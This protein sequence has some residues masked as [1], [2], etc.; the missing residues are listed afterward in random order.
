MHPISGA[1]AG[2]FCDY[3]ADDSTRTAHSARIRSTQDEAQLHASTRLVSQSFSVLPVV[4]PAQQ[5]G[6]VKVATSGRAWL[7]TMLST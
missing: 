7:E 6:E 3:S 5:D 4:D 1:D 2:Q